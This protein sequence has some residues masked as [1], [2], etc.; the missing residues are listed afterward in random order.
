MRR[1]SRYLLGS[2]SYCL[3]DFGVGVSGSRDKVPQSSFRHCHRD[4]PANSTSLP[5]KGI[6]PRKPF[7]EGPSRDLSMVGVRWG[8]V[9]S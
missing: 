1:A 3:E 2:E 7:S 8:W 4:I 6:T 9:E 5:A